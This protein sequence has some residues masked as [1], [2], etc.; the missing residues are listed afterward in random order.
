MDNTI[1][2]DLEIQRAINTDKFEVMDGKYKCKI[3][4]FENYYKE[5][6]QELTDLKQNGFNNVE[7]SGW[8]KI[9]K[10]LISYGVIF[11][12]EIN[13]L[14]VFDEQN[15]GELIERINRAD[16]VVGFNHINFDYTVLSQYGT[17]NK[18]VLKDYDIMQKVQS[19]VGKKKGTGLDAIAHGTIGGNKSDDGADAPGM[20]L[21][22]EHARL[23]NYCMD[24]VILT[25]DLYEFIMLNG[26]VIFNGDKLTVEGTN[27]EK[28]NV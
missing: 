13:K 5:Y 8:G 2:F 1:V 28:S 18:S 23:I 6:P 19:K 24:D 14:R 15:V 3:K 26:Y 22:G 7:V 20:W 25:K 4:G 12:Y 10:T 11:D 9:D 27:K 17:V 16:K 21:R